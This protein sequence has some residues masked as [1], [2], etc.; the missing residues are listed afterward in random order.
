MAYELH[1]F[2]EAREEFDKLDGQQRLILSKGLNRI[3]QYG[4]DAGQ[5][6]VGSL[7]GW[8]KLKFKR[9][10]LRIVFGQ[11]DGQIQVVDIAAVG[12]RNREEVY[13][14]AVQRIR[15]QNQKE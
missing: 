7:I 12:Y 6:L 1:W 5:P 14:N 10:G 4:L 9:L 13:N 3:R 15:Q 2:P 11:V 8:R